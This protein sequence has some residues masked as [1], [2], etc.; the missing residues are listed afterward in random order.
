M[1]GLMALMIAAAGCAT[2]C[3]ALAP[4][5]TARRYDLSVEFRRGEFGPEE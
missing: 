1:G 5:T 2:A 3:I 4:S